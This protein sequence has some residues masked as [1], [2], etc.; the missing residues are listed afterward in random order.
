M[1]NT[2]TTRDYANLARREVMAS[3]LD[4]DRK[5]VPGFATNLDRPAEEHDRL[6]EEIDI[7]AR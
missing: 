5:V 2:P 1:D 7:I 3:S 4:Q 6:L